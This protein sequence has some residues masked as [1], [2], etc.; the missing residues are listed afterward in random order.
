L[1]KTPASS[2][3]SGATVAVTGLRGKSLAWASHHRRVAIESLSSLLASWLTSLMTWL[4]IGIA[5]SLPIILYLMLVNVAEISGDWD[6]KPR[7]S[8]YLVQD[9]SESD[10]RDLARRLQDRPDVASTTFISSVEALV[11][12]RAMSGF[13]DVL[14]TLD[15][16]PL[17]AVIEIRPSTTD[18]SQLRL[19]VASLAAYELVDTVAFDLEWIERLFAILQ[20]GERL[21]AAIGFVLALGVLLI[22]GNTIRLAIENRR[23]EIEIIKLVGGTDSFVRRPFLY[24]GFW[25]GVGGALIA[26]ILVEGSLEFLAAPVET[27]AQ[28][29]RDD[30][31]LAGPGILDSL[32]ILGAGAGL[33]I[34]G[35]LFAV[36]RHL[37]EIEPE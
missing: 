34:L 18:I 13:G 20:F 21:V 33:G 24:L 10:A 7:I 8:L 2:S 22:I 4:V 32:V 36:S 9:A 29:Y 23:S 5:L 17:P 30:F 31:S 25:Y 19:Q 37:K 35:A 11:Q 28:S 16:N 27:L 14:N 12:F 6:G 3:T 15:R 26:W 1:T